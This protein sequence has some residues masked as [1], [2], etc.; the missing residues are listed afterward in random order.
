MPWGR[1]EPMEQKLMFLARVLE[2]G[3]NFKDLCEEYQ[4]SR[5]TGYKL[6]KR[7]QQ[8]GTEQ[9]IVD[10]SRKPKSCPNQIRGDM[11]AEIVAIRNA[12]PSWGGKKIQE[13]LKR[14]YG[15]EGTPSIRT[16]DR[17][18][19]RCGLVEARK[20]RRSKTYRTESIIRP[21]APNDVWTVDFK[22]WWQ[23]KNGDRCVPLTIR[24]EYSRYLLDFSALSYGNTA[25]VKEQFGLPKYIR[26]DNGS[27]FANGRS[28][29]G[30]TKLSVW[31]LKN[32]ILPNRIQPGNPQQNGA[33]ERLH[34]DIKAELQRFPARCLSLQGEIFKQWKKDFNE[35]RP[36]EALS[37]KTP[38]EVYKESERRYS[39][40]IKHFEYGDE[41]EIRK[42]CSRGKISW[43]G[44]L[45]F[46]AQALEGEC[47]GLKLNHNSLE[48]SVWY[49]N[50]CLGETDVDFSHPLGGEWLHPYLKS[51]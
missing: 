30:L 50:L 44:T 5:T 13:I 38:S 37:M 16:V 23:V 29:A 45:Q 34:R 9:A 2:G 26:S 10:Q 36:H 43:R 8:L 42:V 47:L 41:F 24:D 18:L 17:L 22:G 32:G 14:R 11:V 12:H 25:E 1:V 40:K 51:V 3:E 46:I 35:V 27:P 21:S 28:V 4:I 6:M 7:Y 31:W 48:L 15:S 49:R 19:A 20:R 33:H 39:R